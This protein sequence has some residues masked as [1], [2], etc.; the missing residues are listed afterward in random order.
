MN[1]KVNE[2]FRIVK[3][4][5]QILEY[6]LQALLTLKNPVWWFTGIYEIES[7]KKLSLSQI[8]ND[9]TVC[10]YIYAIIVCLKLPFHKIINI[11]TLFDIFYCVNSS[12]GQMMW[13]LR[14]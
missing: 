9:L 8:L 4:A 5:L 6:T 3:C 11:I 12:G 2:G 10:G 13:V 7:K 14:F 1:I